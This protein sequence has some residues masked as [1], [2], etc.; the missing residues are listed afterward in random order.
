MRAYECCLI[1]C[2]KCQSQTINNLHLQ[3]IK[4]D[5]MGGLA[6]GLRGFFGGESDHDHAPDKK[7][8]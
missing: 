5:R 8:N 2:S 6:V 1:F 3:N 4:I 7:E